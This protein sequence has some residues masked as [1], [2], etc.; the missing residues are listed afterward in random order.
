MRRQDQIAEARPPLRH[1]DRRTTA[2]AYG[3]RRNPVSE[4][5]ILTRLAAH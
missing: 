4:F 2:L 1:L 5:D 3:I